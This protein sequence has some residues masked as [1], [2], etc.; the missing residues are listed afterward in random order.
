MIGNRYLNRDSAAYEQLVTLLSDTLRITIIALDGEV[1]FDNF[2]EEGGMENHTRRPEIVQAKIEGHGDAVRM[3]KTMEKKYFYYAVATPERFIRLAL[4]YETSAKELLAGDN[5]FIYFLTLLFAASL[6]ALLFISDRMSKSINQLR[7]FAM[8]AREGDIP[9]D[10]E[11]PQSELGDIGRE[12]VN[13]YTMLA[14]VNSTL[15]LEQEKMHQHFMLA[16]EGVA[17]FN[18]DMNILYAN[19][20]Y[21]KYINLITDVPT[22]NVASS[23]QLPQFAPLLAFREEHIADEDKNSHSDTKSL[24]LSAGSARIEAEILIFPDHSFEIIL[25]DVTQLEEEKKLKREMSSNIAHELRTPVASIQGYLETLLR[26]QEVS[27]EQQE[28]FLNKAHQQTLRLAELINDITAITLSEEIAEKR[29]FE[30]MDLEIIF[31]SIIQEFQPQ[32]EKLKINISNQLPSPLAVHADRSLLPAILRNLISNSL[33]HG[34]EEFTLGMRLLSED[35]NS[36]FL[37]YYDTGRGVP[38]ESLSRIFERFYRV[39][40]GRSRQNGGSGLGLSIVK[41]ALA[42]HGSPVYARVP[43][44]GGLEILFSLPK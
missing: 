23:Y 29:E 5:I 18:R 43:N 42:A 20:L 11:M 12:I 19:T 41:N 32:I 13:A 33:R 8:R 22:F 6:I 4:P 37:C 30:E 15:Q 27:R 1:L 14:E 39:D 36:V 2:K 35:E 17:I 25:R 10:I 26:T 21:I 34:G 28:H 9:H 40:L 44:G 16:K 24:L 38:S 3:S 7:A 31:S